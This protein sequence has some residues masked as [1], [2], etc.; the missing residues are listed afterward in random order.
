VFESSHF[1]K[2]KMMKERNILSQ[3]KHLFFF[4]A[5]HVFNLIHYDD[6]PIFE[7]EGIGL[8]KFAGEQKSVGLQVQ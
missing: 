4:K 5:V 6:Q 8:Y 3:V 1:P 2:V 7:P